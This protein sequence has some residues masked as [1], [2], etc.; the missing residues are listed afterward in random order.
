[1][2]TRQALRTLSMLL[3]ALTL[4]LAACG[5]DQS[6]ATSEPATG[7]ETESEIPSGND[8]ET[9]EE[10]P[11]AEEPTAAPEDEIPDILVVHPEAANIEVNEASN[12][13]VYVV[14]MM[15]Q[16]SADYLIEELEAKGWEELGQPTI[17]GHLATLNLQQDGHRLTI[18]LQDN[19]R[20]ETTR[21]Q[22]LLMEQ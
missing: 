17:M 5:G 6:P 21:V 4:L 11:A 3:V 22:M 13:Y 2:R 1:M 7:G 15:V 16:E 12:T 20:T 9:G 18:S 8:D 19:E 14:P 10:A